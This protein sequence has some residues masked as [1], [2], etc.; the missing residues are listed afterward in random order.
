MVLLIA[1]KWAPSE[2]NLKNLS[3]VCG[4][5][6]SSWSKM[7]DFLV[8]YHGVGHSDCLL[9]RHWDWHL[10]CGMTCK[11]R[12]YIL[13]TDLKH[14][15]QNMFKVTQLLGDNVEIH[16]LS[17]W[18]QKLSLSL[19]LSLASHHRITK[20][21]KE[22]VSLS[23]RSFRRQLICPGGCFSFGKASRWLVFHPVLISSLSAYMWDDC[24]TLSCLQKSHIW[25]YQ[26]SCIFSTNKL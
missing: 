26:I 7:M 2:S 23:T 14:E 22:Q 9:S 25:W 4:L 16:L 15:D 1:K 17:N 21:R 3:T 5:L 12:N 10:T 6:N 24:L 13:P 19:A 8:Y 20:Y 11:I 18:L